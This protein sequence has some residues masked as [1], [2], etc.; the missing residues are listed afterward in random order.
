M[1]QK[2]KPRPNSVSIRQV[3]GRLLFVLMV[4]F[5]TYVSFASFLTNIEVIKQKQVLAA[6]KDGS[7]D[8][9]SQVLKTAQ[10]GTNPVIRNLLIGNAFDS[11]ALRLAAVEQFQSGNSRVGFDLLSLARRASRRD[12]ATQ[13]LLIEWYASRDD[14]QKVVTLYDE[15]LRTSG[16]ARTVLFPILARALDDEDVRGAFV[17]LLKLKTNWMVDFLYFSGFRPESTATT[18]KLIQQSGTLSDDQ[19]A[20]QFQSRFLAHLIASHLY[21]DANRL[22]RRMAGAEPNLLSDVRFSV[23]RGK[24]QFRPIAW[25]LKEGEQV[26]SRFFSSETKRGGLELNVL[27]TGVVPEMAAY[28]IAY[29][30]PGAYRLHVSAKTAEMTAGSTLEWIVQCLSADNA[31]EIARVEIT[32]DGPGK[33]KLGAPFSVSATCEAVRIFANAKGGVDDSTSQ[34]VVEEVQIVPS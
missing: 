15:A 4:L 22:Y 12:V 21:D 8:E 2:P 9:A 16:A 34:V 31:I 27:A 6:P 13:I 29:L 19:Y 30:K 7:V 26:E 11:T 17:P 23:S 18:A 20:R 24:G 1:A 33:D 5:V 14:L 3:A 25:E 32:R 10:S 28:R